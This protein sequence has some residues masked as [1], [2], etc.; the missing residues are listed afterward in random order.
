VNIKCARPDEST[1]L[2]A[3]AVSA[4]SRWGYSAEQIA[5]WQ[6]QL[7]IS[8]ESITSEPTFVAEESGHLAGVVQLKRAPVS[9]H[10]ECLWVQPAA[11]NRGIGSSLVRHAAAYAREH[12]QY[13]LHIDADPHAESF[14]LK[15]GARR[16]GKVSAP[17]EGQPR[18]IRPQLLL[19]IDDAAYPFVAPDLL[20]RALPA[21][22]SG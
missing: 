19:C 20:Q 1:Q 12:G 16:V 7:H 4:K 6:D 9:W 8:A 10:I 3:L 18:R 5:L 2:T 14:Y 13:E 22:A 17:I 21:S 15:L 11:A